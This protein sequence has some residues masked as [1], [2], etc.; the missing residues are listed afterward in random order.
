M[1]ANKDKGNYGE[2][3]VLGYLQGKGYEILK[4]NYKKY[5]GEIDIIA[6][7]GEYIVFIEVK[8]RRGAGFGDGLEAITRAKQKRIVKTAKAYLYEEKKW[9]AACRF[10][11]LSVFGREVLEIEHIENVFGE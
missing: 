1:D 10:D 8:Y 5:D 7:D 4:Q 2:A 9:D 6:Q 3:V 11:V